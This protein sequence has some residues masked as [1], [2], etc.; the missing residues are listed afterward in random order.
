MAGGVWINSFFDAFN[1]TVLVNTNIGEA[2]F[3]LESAVG[4]V[5]VCVFGG[6]YPQQ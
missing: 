4:R 3:N 1:A 6:V 2:L 5:E